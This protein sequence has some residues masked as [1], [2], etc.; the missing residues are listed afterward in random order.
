MAAVA[1]VCKESSS[2]IG[3]SQAAA[4]IK[5]AAFATPDAAYDAIFAAAMPFQYADYDIFFA[6]ITTLS[7][8]IRYFRCFR[9]FA[10]PGLL[11][12]Y[13]YVDGH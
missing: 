5:N 12:W 2:G 7:S 6:A 4:V 13:T 10:P 9:R 11:R 1:T 3:N 8:T